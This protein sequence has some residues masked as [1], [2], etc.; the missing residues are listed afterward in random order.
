MTRLHI[1]MISLNYFN[2]N[3]PTFSS[4]NPI[5]HLAMKIDLLPALAALIQWYKLTKL[6]YIMEGDEAFE[7]FQTIMVAQA[8]E[9]SYDILEIEGRQIVN[10]NNINQT[11]TLLQSVEINDRGTKEERYIVLDL[12][13][14]QSYNR[15]LML[16]RQSAMTTPHYH[17][18]LMSLVSKLQEKSTVTNI[19]LF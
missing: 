10:M 3:K 17:Y 12:K 18:I 19:C 16:I 8:R 6:F 15:L 11:K 14:T 13:D 2:Y 7:R 9:K 5:F 1:S 4:R